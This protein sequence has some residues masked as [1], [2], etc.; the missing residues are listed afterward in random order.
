MASQRPLTQICYPRAPGDAQYLEL[1][2]A[3]RTACINA[4]K[5]NNLVLHAT[6]AQTTDVTYTLRQGT[7]LH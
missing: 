5:A 7:T 4:T 3:T 1:L 6:P 2:S